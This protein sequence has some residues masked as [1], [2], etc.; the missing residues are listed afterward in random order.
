MPQQQGQYSS[1]DVQQPTGAFTAADIDTSTPAPR[2]WLDSATDFAKGV[3][4]QVNPVSGIKGA[5]Q[6]A[7]HP[8][9][10]Y[11]QDASNRQELLDKAESAFKK[12]NYGE[13]VM[14]A[15]YGIVPFIGPQAEQS[16]NNLAQGNTATGLGQATG[17]GLAFAGP[18][19]I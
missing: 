14:H 16:A 15:L 9:D 3:W 11:V 17:M 2:T 18:K 5:A 13:G 4:Q 19:A 8:I 1:S 10:S 12:G 6:L 7:A